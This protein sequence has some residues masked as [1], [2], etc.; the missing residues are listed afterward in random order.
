MP[1]FGTPNIL[2]EAIVEEYN[3]Q[4]AMVIACY[5]TN[6][7]AKVT[8][9]GA[10]FSQQYILQKGLKKFEQRG[11]QAAFKELDQLHR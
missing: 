10:T 1:F 4:L 11:T 6:I 7:N 3:P 9:Q 8:A 5:M 2:P